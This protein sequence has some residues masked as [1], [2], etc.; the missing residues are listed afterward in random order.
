MN[1]K[2]NTFS[3]KIDPSLATKLGEDL[4]NQGFNLTKPEYTIF[5]A[6]KKGIVCTLYTSGSLVVQGKDKD[7]FIEFYLE[8]E[9]LKNFIY[10]NPEAFADMT[11]RIGIDE[12]GKGD[13]FGP[14]CIAGCFADT[15]GIKKLI[16]IGVKDSKTFSDTSILKMAKELKQ[17]CVF[18]LVVL[19]PEKY[20][21]LYEKFKNLNHLLAWAHASAIFNLFQKTN[22]TNVLIDQFAEKHVVENAVKRKNIEI[23]LKQMHKAESD[24]VVAAAS[25]LARAAFLEG[26][27]KLSAK[28]NF[29]LPKGASSRVIDAGVKI[30][31][32]FGQEE[33]K[34][35]S[36]VHFKTFQ[37]V[38]EK[39]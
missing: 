13:F 5:S 9:I 20:N 3:V 35:V 34:K 30:A 23:N 4:K 21:E 22:C 15:E 7:E 19:F 1:A 17:F 2:K 29:P 25:I 11:P 31:S 36:K 27:E 10:T 24:P 12:A 39:L 28:I 18:D 38:L 26:L 16:S 8:P 32:K 6:Q 33:L 37:D 14:L